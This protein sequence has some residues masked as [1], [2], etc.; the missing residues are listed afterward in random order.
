MRAFA[1]LVIAGCSS[2]RAEGLPPSTSWSED[3]AGGVALPDQPRAKMPN[4]HGDDDDPHRGVPGAP[5]INDDDDPHRGVP[6]A[7][8]LAQPTEDDEPVAAHVDP[9]PA[10]NPA[11]RV[12]GT[13]KLGAPAQSLVKPGGVIFLMAKTP[14]A[15][16]QPTGTALAIERYLW[17]ADGMAFEMGGASGDVLVIARYD[18]DGDGSTVEPGDVIGMTR[19]KVPSDNVVI[20]LS[21]VAR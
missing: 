7:P 11:T 20:E 10:S 19:V 17:N 18:Q 13:L 16:G 14:D 12:R 21:T 5:P 3:P 1:L 2:E 4:P 6:G 8:P 15:S 9:Q